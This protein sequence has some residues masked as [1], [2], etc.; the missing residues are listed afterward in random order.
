VAVPTQLLFGYIG[1]AA[2]VFSRNLDGYL[3]MGTCVPATIKSEI[4]LAP[5]YITLCGAAV[6]VRG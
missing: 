5:A 3:R 4:L 1:V 6:S 2:A